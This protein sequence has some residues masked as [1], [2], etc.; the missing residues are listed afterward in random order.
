MEQGDLLIRSAKLSRLAKLAKNDL[1]LHGGGGRLACTILL[2]EGE[3]LSIVANK[4]SGIAE[5]ERT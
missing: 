1:Q 3:T 4:T 5:D 2:I